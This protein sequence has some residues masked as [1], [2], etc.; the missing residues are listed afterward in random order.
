MRIKQTFIYGFLAVAL[1]FTV[2][3]LTG[4][5][6]PDPILVPSGH[7]TTVITYNIDQKDGKDFTAT[8][9]G[10]VFNFSASVD[11]LNPA[12]II[13]GG[14]AEIGPATLSGSGKRWT[15]ETITVNNAGLA[16]VSINKDGIE[17]AQK[18]VIVFKTGE[19]APEYWTITWNLNG[20]AKGT[21][22]YP[23]QVVKGTVLARPSPDPAKAN[24]TFAG[25]YSNSGLTQAYNFANPVSAN[26]SLYAKWEAV[27]GPAHIHNW[28]VWTATEL[29]GTEER[30]CGSNA[31][32][33]EARL[34]GTERFNFWLISGTAAYGV[35]RETAIVGTVRIPAYYRPSDELEYQPVTEIAD[36]AFGGCTS[37]SGINIPA[38]VTSIGNGAFSGCSILTNI[39]VDTNNPNYAG[40]GG[41]LYNKTKTMLVAYPSASG[42][43]TIPAN[44]T[45]IGNEAFSTSSLTTVTF[46]AGSQLQTIGQQAFYN[47]SSLASITIPAG[48]TSIGDRAFYNC[49]SLAS[50]TIPAG[51]TE[52][53]NEAFS[54]GYGV[55]TSS[56][57][58]VTFAAG[59]QL[60][61]IGDRAFSGC[62]RLTSI[63]IP[64]GVTSIGDSAFY[65]CSSLTSITIPANVTSIGDRA[66]YNCSSL[67]S[68]T[69]PANVTEIGG[70][71][72]SG[73]IR[74]TTVNIP[75]SVTEIGDSA[76]YNCSSLAS[77]T[78]PEGVTY[79][80]ASAFSG[81]TNSQT[82]YIKGYA[83]ESAANSAWGYGWQYDC[84][85]VR[86]YW[87]GSEY[88]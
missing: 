45:E 75:A 67:A 54:R 20:G 81:W 59:S 83:S 69:I 5:P 11:S 21:G 14:A 40:E 31:T 4:C 49:S 38:S 62:S 30:V 7:S 57:A 9:T 51:V 33:I 71:V 13:V 15:L 53:G 44:V 88:Q 74:L 60:Q 82:I 86:K 78:I 72:F 61:T 34:T 24:N 48:V 55:P 80:G 22:A 66:F 3:S 63:T 76:F 19:Y 68:I 16:T 79:I 87:N 39:T 56:L 50:I 42:N 17:A 18:S 37:L 28:G 25:W 32:H 26:L 46:A 2:L 52:I 85:A 47:C 27:G 43:V 64:A 29:A 41:I 77:I 1:A 73:C 58:T 84:N 12:D 70:W 23:D 6:E 65:N 10:I 8:S 36:S 35:S